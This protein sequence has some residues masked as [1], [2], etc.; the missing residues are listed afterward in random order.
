MIE[1]KLIAK[2]KITEFEREV[3]DHRREGTWIVVQGT[4]VAR[5]KHVSG[6]NETIPYY[7]ES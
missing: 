3:N 2:D 6:G 5:W 7:K 1:Q 4:H